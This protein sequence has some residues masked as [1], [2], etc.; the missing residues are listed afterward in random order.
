MSDPATPAPAPLNI[1]AMKA[2]ALRV[3]ADLKSVAPAA[4]VVPPAKDT[5]GKPA[6]PPSVPSS[7]KAAAAGAPKEGAVVPPQSR[8]PQNPPEALRERLEESVRDLAAKAAVASFLPAVQPILVKAI[9]PVVSLEADGRVMLRADDSTTQELTA[10]AVSALLGEAALL[11]TP[12]TGVPG[13]G[14]SPPRAFPGDGLES[15]S[16]LSSQVEFERNAPRG[17]RR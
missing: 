16:Y 9:R 10:A 17:R 4:P 6:T 12:S 15:R 5:E 13:S 14:A 8:R 11:F 7:G 3:L 2:E 1:E